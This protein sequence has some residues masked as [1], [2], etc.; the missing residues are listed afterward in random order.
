MLH[1]GFD[2]ELV[3]FVHFEQPVASPGLARWTSMP[4]AALDLR[5]PGYFVRPALAYR[6]TQYALDD[7]AAGQ[8]QRS[9]SRS[10]PIASLDSGLVFERDDAARTISAS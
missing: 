5:G 6:F 2:S 7:R 9:P 3:N 1:Y 4:A 10:L 8:P